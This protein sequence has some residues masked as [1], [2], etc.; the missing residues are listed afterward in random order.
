MSELTFL[1][2]QVRAAI[3]GNYKHD[4][5]L[6][7]GEEYME[8]VIASALKDARE[9]GRFSIG[10]YESKSGDHITF[11]LVGKALVLQEVSQSLTPRQSSTSAQTITAHEAALTS[12]GITK[13]QLA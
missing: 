7:R 13:E 8:V 3:I 10:R 4:R 11:E 6:G 2:F 5:L 1:E 9:N 12:E